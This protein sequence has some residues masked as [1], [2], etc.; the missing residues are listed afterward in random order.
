[1]ENKEKQEKMENI[2][3]SMIKYYRDCYF[4]KC[5]YSIML[6]RCLNTDNKEIKKFKGFYHFYF[7]DFSISS[8]FWNSHIKKFIQKEIKI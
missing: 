7:N 1:M 5:E 4:N 8:S 3:T 6:V 2:I